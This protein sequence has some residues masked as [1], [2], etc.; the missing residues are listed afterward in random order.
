[1][2]WVFS[3]GFAFTRCGLTC[4]FRLLNAIC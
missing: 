2:V 3:D 1:L 4:S